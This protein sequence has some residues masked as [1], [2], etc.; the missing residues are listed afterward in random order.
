MTTNEIKL[1]DN[2]LERPSRILYIKSFDDCNF[3]T[4]NEIIDDLLIYKQYKE[5]CIE[6]ISSLNIITID[7]IKSVVREINIHNETPS[8]F[9][10]YFNVKISND[11]YDVYEIKEGKE[12]LIAIDVPNENI[13]PNEII[14][15]ENI[16]KSFQL[17]GEYQGQIKKIIDKS[18]FIVS[19]DEKIKT[20][21]LE[22]KN[23]K[24]RS[25][26]AF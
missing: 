16:G 13:F 2:Y 8:K 26:N 12:E 25:F 19:Y 9:A 21:K 7:I 18:T 10:G 23:K 17:Y 11:Y 14:K 3:A 24:H 1:N 22:L 15:Q 20:Y 4:I 5:E 6:F